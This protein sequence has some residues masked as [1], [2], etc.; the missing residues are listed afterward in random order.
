MRPA[1]LL[2]AAAPLVLA[3][4]MDQLPQPGSA[5]DNVVR[6]FEAN[7]PASGAPFPPIAIFDEAGKPFHTSALKGRWSVLVSGCLT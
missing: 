1:L 5:G 2:F 6:Q 7:A 4:R 3:Q